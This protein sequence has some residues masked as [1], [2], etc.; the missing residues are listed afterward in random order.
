MMKKAAYK[1][2]IEHINEDEV[3]LDKFKIGKVSDVILSYYNKDLPKTSDVN[4]FTKRKQRYS[5]YILLLGNYALPIHTFYFDKKEDADKAYKKYMGKLIDQRLEKYR[6]KV[7]KGYSLTLDEIQK[8]KEIQAL[9]P[10]D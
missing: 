5:F 2:V 7:E 1:Q 10:E 6:T 4:E 9:L 8:C 3:N